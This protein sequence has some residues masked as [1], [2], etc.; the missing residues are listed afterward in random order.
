MSTIRRH[1]AGSLAPAEDGQAVSDVVYHP[2][3]A[4][5]PRR[6]TA[7]RSYWQREE[8][9]WYPMVSSMA[10]CMEWLNG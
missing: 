2:Y 4:V 5:R 7:L 10:Y 9:Y 3:T 8:P 6:R 1:S